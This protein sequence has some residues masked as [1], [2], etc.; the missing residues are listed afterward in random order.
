MDFRVDLTARAFDEILA[1][2]AYIRQRG[3][4]ESAEKWL[5]AIRQSVDN[6]RFLSG[7]HPV[8]VE[9]DEVGEKTRILLH[10]VKNRTYKIFY[11]IDLRLRVVYVLHVRHWARS[12][13]TKAEMDELISHP[14]KSPDSD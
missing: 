13:P 11:S 10:G 8:L 5:V 12:T 1:I 2:A 7:V 9:S 4:V 3:S 6:L 14:D